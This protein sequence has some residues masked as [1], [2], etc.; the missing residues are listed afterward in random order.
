MRLISFV[1]LVLVSITAH[2]EKKFYEKELTGKV[3]R[4]H[5]GDTCRVLVNGK[6]MSIRFSGVD[7]PEL[8]QSFGKEARDFTEGLLKGKIVTL[9][10]TGQSYNRTACGV[11]LE[12]KDVVEEIVANGWGFDS[13]KY[14][15]GA[16][17]EAERIAKQAKAGLWKAKDLVSPHCFRHMTDKRCY[18]NPSFMP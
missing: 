2:G 10:C 6:E 8:N 4:C 9:K 18:S 5:D 16:Y 17:K 1:A 12:A 3:L 15:H 13:T 14:S 11:F 7:T